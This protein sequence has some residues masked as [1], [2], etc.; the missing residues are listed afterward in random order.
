MSKKFLLE[1]FV[2]NYDYSIYFCTVFLTTSDSTDNHK[3]QFDY[4]QLMS[5]LIMVFVDEKIPV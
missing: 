5:Y 2:Y 4:G 1:S 3:L